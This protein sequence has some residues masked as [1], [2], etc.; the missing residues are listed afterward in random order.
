LSKR[1]PRKTTT[2]NYGAYMTK[3]EENF[4]TAKGAMGTALPALR[5]RRAGEKTILVQPRTGWESPS[6]ISRGDL[7]DAPTPRPAWRDAESAN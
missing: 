6:I 3:N 2:V 7:H 4:A 1:W 5:K